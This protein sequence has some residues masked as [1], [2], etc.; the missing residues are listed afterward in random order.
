MNIEAW[1]GN[2][3]NLDFNDVKGKPADQ[4]K[5]WAKDHGAPAEVLLAGTYRPGVDVQND[6]LHRPAPEPFRDGG[7][8]GG[9]AGGGAGL[10]GGGRGGMGGGRGGNS[11][12]AGDPVQ[13]G[14]KEPLTLCGITVS[15]S[16]RKYVEPVKD[17]IQA[18]VDVQTSSGTWQEGALLRRGETI[19]IIGEGVNTTKK[20]KIGRDDEHGYFKPFSDLDHSTAAFYGQ[21]K[22]L[23]P[24]H[25]AA[26]WQFAKTMG[27]EYAQL[28]S[29]CIIRE[30][31][32]QLGS[33]SYG[34]SGRVS[35]NTGIPLSDLPKDQVNNLAFYDALIGQQDRHGGNFIVDNRG[36]VGIDHG[37]TFARNRDRVNASKFQRYRKQREPELTQNEFQLLV[38]ITKSDDCLGM[39]KII[40]A[41]RADSLKR[42]AEAMLKSGKIL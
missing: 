28:V 35:N 36:V 39:K 23:Q 6:N 18:L 22:A 15:D 41:K 7:M 3:E 40:G 8:A 27:P 42:R 21:D 16:D 14:N 24:I 2:E 1:A 5:I 32:G 12:D 31:G 34:Q 20:I 38:K 19:R 29:P 37:F 4:L 11:G 10:G 25:E 33:V 30:V 26:A 13:G 9:F 17:Q